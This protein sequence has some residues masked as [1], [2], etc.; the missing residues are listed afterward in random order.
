MLEDEEGHAGEVEIH[1]EHVA[2]SLTIPEGDEDDHDDH[3]DH[4][5]LY[6][7]DAADD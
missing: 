1:A 5:L 4:C 3:D 6:T 2:H 7:S